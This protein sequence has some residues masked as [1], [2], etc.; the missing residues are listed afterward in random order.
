MREIT[1]NEMNNVSG[2]GDVNWVDVGKMRAAYSLQ[3]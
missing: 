1:L 2:A 3:L